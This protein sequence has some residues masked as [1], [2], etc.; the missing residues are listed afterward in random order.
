MTEN[1]DLLQTILRSIQESND[2]QTKE[3]KTYI[4]HEIEEIKQVINQEKEKFSKLEEKYEELESKYKKLKESLKKNN[5]IIFGLQ[6]KTG[7]L[8]DYTL[9]KLNTHLEITLNS[10]DINN[11][12]TIGKRQENKPIIVQFTSFLQ[13]LNVLRNCRKLKNTGITISEDLTPEGRE[14]LSI[15]RSHL[16][17]ARSKNFSAYIRGNKLYVNGEIYTVKQLIDSEGQTDAGEKETTKEDG[18]INLKLREKEE[19][20]N[21]FGKPENIEDVEERKGESE[22]V[23]KN[24]K[25]RK[26]QT[27]Q[28]KCSTK[29]IE[30]TNIS[31]SKGH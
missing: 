16:I 5:I 12:Y 6:Y 7:S 3:L 14:E 30:R 9:T 22:E 13:K 17:K 26:I 11:I 27:R 25:K 23:D 2:K 20:G 29:N 8:L 18:N 28:D 4:N 10:S 24:L 19:L 15:L 1:N 21:I 31:K